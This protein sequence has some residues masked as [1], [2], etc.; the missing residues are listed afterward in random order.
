MGKRIEW[1]DAAKGIGI[2]LVVAGHVPTT[3]PIKQFIYSF[4]MPLFFFLS[5]LVFKSKDLGLKSFIQKKARSLLFPYVCFAIITYLFWFTVE[6]HL[7]FSSD[8]DVD[9]F[10]PFMGIFL[11]IEDNHMMTYNPAVWFLTAL[12]LVELA[13]FLYTK[14][15]KGRFVVL[16]AALCGAIGY[17]GSLRLEGSLPWNVDVVFTAIAFYAFG[18]AMK[19]HLAQHKPKRTLI[20][21][22][23]LFIV[24]AYVES[25]NI[26]VDMRGNDY[27]NGL[28]FYLASLL[29]IAG[30]IYLSHKLK[31]V[32]FLTYLGRNSIVILLLQFVAI[33]IVKTFI[34]YGMEIDIKD[35][36]TAAWTLFY[37]VSILLFMIPCISFLNKYPLLLGKVSQRRIENL[38]S[39]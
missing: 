16:F 9:P 24:T 31:R 28:V 10:T 17:Y 11:S 2:I 29:G 32:A 30:T 23:L 26:R 37:T 14:L 3:D 21:C 38:Q 36:D 25:Y 4:H 15:T 5:G 8:S 19:N 18:Y 39:R 6:R 1:I 22:V 34:Y 7:P 20:T 27:G 33:P 12:F 35:T 13:F